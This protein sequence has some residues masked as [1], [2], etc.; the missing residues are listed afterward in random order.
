VSDT[1]QQASN[2]RDSDDSAALVDK[3]TL[4]SRESRLLVALDFDGTLAPEVDDPYAARALP[5]A[6]AAL[7]RLL[8]LPN[9]RVAL[10]SGRAM[11]SLEQVANVPDSVLLVGSHGVEFRLDTPDTT[12]DLDTVELEQVEAL[13]EVLEDVAAGLDQVWVETKPAGFAL[14]TRLATEKDSRIAHMQAL[15]ET[16]AE[17]AGLTVREGKNVIEF[18]VRSATK[19]EA[20]LHLKEYTKATAIFYAGDDVTDEDAFA[21]LRPHDFGLKSGPGKTIAEFRVADPREVAGVLSLLATL[22]ARAV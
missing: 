12:V 7:F 1:L 4:L 18:S 17:I 5:E 13:S 15:S 3:L 11:A 6:R 21:V 9:T 14:H 2:I 19:G 16:Q 10:I 22:R 8:A 20:L